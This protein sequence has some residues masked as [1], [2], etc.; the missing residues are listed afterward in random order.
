MFKEKSID[1]LDVTIFK[2]GSFITFCKMEKLD[3]GATVKDGESINGIISEVEELQFSVFLATGDKKTIHI[4]EIKD[5]DTQ[6]PS[7]NENKIKILGIQ[8]TVAEGK[9]VMEKV[10]KSYLKN[11]YYCTTGNCDYT[12]GVTNE[13]ASESDNKLKAD[14]GYD[15]DKKTLC[16]KCHQNSL[17]FVTN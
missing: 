8:D 13:V 11:N 6:S 9:G 12:T 5:P 16:P 14:G 3:F 1:I 2:I 7:S 10:Q 4:E 15:I 17:I